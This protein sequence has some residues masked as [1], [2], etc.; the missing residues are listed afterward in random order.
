[1]AD[2]I[3]EITIRRG[4]DPRDYTLVVGG[5]AGG[6]HAAQIADELGIGRVVVP[7]IASAFC[8]FGAVVADVRH[9]YTRSYAQAMARLDLPALADALDSLQAEGRRAL[10]EEGVE[11]AAMRFLRSLELR[12]KDQVWE[13]TVDVSDL[14]L[15][16]GGRDEVEARFHARHLALYD[17]SQPGYP[18]ELISATVTALGLTPPLAPARRAPAVDGA[19]TRRRVRFERGAEAVEATVV[20][21][22]RSVASPAVIEEPNTTI[23]VPPGW[24]AT[25]DEVDQAYVLERA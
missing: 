5:G 4:H 19:S 1:M 20:G 6:L 7:R 13:C 15:R 22:G 11:Q 24:S 17:Y 14:D 23:A 21:G 16:S 8:A 12:Y 18:C 3:R 25:F 10:A 9:D 2:A